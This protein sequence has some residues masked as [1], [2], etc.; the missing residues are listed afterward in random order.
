[1]I[2]ELYLFLSVFSRP[3]EEVDDL[4]GGN[5]LKV[6]KR[7]RVALYHK[8]IESPESAIQNTN[9]SNPLVPAA[10]ALAVLPYIGRNSISDAFQ[11]LM[12]PGSP[13]YDLIC[14]CQV[15]QISTSSLNTLYL[16]HS[17]TVYVCM[18]FN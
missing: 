10:C 1:M 5:H 4:L 18:Y 8:R 6:N 3:R 2:I 13:I 15:R 12:D 7:S 16:C 9:I 17:R 14:P 11:C